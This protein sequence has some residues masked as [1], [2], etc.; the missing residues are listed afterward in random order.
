MESVLS[1]D[2]PFL[3]HPL[4]SGEPTKVKADKVEVVVSQGNY[5]QINASLM[6]D[7]L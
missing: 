3:F 6:I 4:F 2:F 5:L 7:N 1:I